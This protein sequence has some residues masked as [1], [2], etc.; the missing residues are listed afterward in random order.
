M[1]YFNEEAYDILLILGKCRGTLATAERLWQ[2]RYTDRTPHSWNVS[3]RLAKQIKIKG[4]FQPQ[5]NKATQ[6]R[7]LIRDERR[8]ILHRQN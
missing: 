8:K 6:I 2:E 7:R 3:S 1:S 4:V 5:Y